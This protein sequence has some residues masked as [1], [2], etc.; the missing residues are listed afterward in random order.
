MGM[1]NLMLLDR[2]TRLAVSGHATQ[3][4]KDDQSPYI[5]HPVMIALI[6]AKAGYGEAVIAAA[7]THDLV[8]DTDMTLEELRRELGDEVA[9][10][11]AS[12]SN[13]DSLS[14]E[15]KKLKYIETVREGSEGAKAVATADKIHNA[16]SLIA[17][18]A[19]LGP[20][21]WDHFNAGRDKKIWFEEKMLEMLKESWQ[22]PLVDEYEALVRKMQALV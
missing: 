17:A 4:R 20:A 13:D 14:W 16:E 12:V 10:I 6:V 19:R 5:T 8:E 3:V 22:H 7:L 1:E 21:L 11:V 15:E 2:A 9:D 18:H